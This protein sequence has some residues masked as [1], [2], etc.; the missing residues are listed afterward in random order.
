M[1]ARF[2]LAVLLVIAL[3]GASGL[4]EGRLGNRWT[5]PIELLAAAGKIS[6]IPDR[7]GDWE[8]Q[9]ARALDDQSV[10]MLQC[11]GGTQRVYRNRRTGQ[12]VGMFLIVGPPGPTSVHT[13][14]ICYSSQDYDRAEDRKLLRVRESERPDETFWKVTMRRKDLSAEVLHVAYAWNAGDGWKAAERPRFA[15][16]SQPFLYKLQLAGFAGPE[17][18][19]VENEPCRA[20]L[21]DFLPALDR[22]LLRPSVGQPS[23]P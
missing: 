19:D 5:K 8:L 6:E 10:K 2:I 23:A 12:N 14:E 4:L 16:A 3:T 18:G 9:T 1:R 21:Q 11:V 15:F 7:F 22:I 17:V 20:F 13:P